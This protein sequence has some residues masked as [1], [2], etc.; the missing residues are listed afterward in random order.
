MINP[1]TAKL[2]T[3]ACKINSFEKAV[4]ALISASVEAKA[5]CIDAL[6]NFRTLSVTIVDNGNGMGRAQMETL[7]SAICSPHN[8]RQNSTS[9]FHCTASVTFQAIIATSNV[10]IRAKTRDDFQTWSKSFWGRSVS[11]TGLAAKQQ[12]GC[13]TTIILTDFMRYQPVRRRQL[14]ET[15]CLSLQMCYRLCHPV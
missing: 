7:G 15:R 14:L 5:D 4:E 10:E 12:I 13:G 3:A 6:V 2:M 9:G 1:D 8:V 11:A